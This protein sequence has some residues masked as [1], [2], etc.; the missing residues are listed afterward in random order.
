MSLLYG[1][2]AIIYWDS[3]QE[4]LWYTHVPLSLFYLNRLV[5]S[6]QS[7]YTKKLQWVA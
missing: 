5:A 2:C 1:S 7:R 4:K 6:R 3:I